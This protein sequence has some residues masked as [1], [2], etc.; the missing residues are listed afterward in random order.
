[1]AAGLAHAHNAYNVP[2][3][4]V[5]FVVQNSEQNIFDQRWIEY[6]LL[7]KHGIITCRKTLAEIGNLAKLDDR[8]LIVP[9]ATTEG[10]WQEISVVYLRAG[11]S[12]SDYPSKIE[13]QG[14][15]LL[16]SSHAIKCPTILTQLAGCKKVQQV[17]SSPTILERLFSLSDTYD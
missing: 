17:L 7:E 11:Y 2:N 1:L 10:S 14:R 4:A 16:E 6:Y 9:S 12:P 5:L 15:R 3:T 8:K 13:W